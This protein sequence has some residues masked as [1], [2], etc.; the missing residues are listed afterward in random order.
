MTLQSAV[1]WWLV[2]TL[3]LVGVYDV[4]AV[5]FGQPNSTVSYELYMLGKRMPTIYL[6]V[7][8]LIGHLVLPLHISDR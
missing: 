6:M 4:W 3:G 8:V 1:C 7:G 2:V 5:L